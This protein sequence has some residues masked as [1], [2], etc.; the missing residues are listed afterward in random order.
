MELGTLKHSNSTTSMC[1]NDE[2][3]KHSHSKCSANEER[4]TML[5]T[6]ALLQN[7][8]DTI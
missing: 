3:N 8:I 7:M 2:H 6:A 1:H 4:N 5:T